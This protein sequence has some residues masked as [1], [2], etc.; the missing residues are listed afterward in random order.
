MN[1][2]ICFLV[3]TFNVLSNFVN[4]FEFDGSYDSKIDPIRKEIFHTLMLEER[5][6]KNLTEEELEREK[7]KDIEAN[8]W[9]KQL[10]ASAKQRDKQK[11]LTLSE[12]IPLELYHCLERKYQ[13]LELSEKN[14]RLFDRFYKKYSSKK[15]FSF[16]KHSPKGF[17]SIEKKL[18]D[19][20]SLP[21]VG[22]EAL[23]PEKSF[24]ELAIDLMERIFTQERLQSKIYRNDLSKQLTSYPLED[25][26]DYLG[27]E[28]SPSDLE[29]FFSPEGQLLYY[30]IYESLHLYLVSE[31]QL[32]HDINLVKQHFQKSLADPDIRIEKIKED[33]LNKHPSLL[34]L[35][36]CDPR[37]LEELTG[38]GF[39]LTVGEQNVADG[40]VVLLEKD[41]WEKEYSLVPIHEYRRSKEGKMNLIIARQKRSHIPFLLA[42]CHG[43]S[44]DPS[45]GR[46]QISII[47]KK[48][49]TLQKKE[50]NLQLLIG[51]DA[52][53]KSQE[54]V[55]S[56]Y[57]HLESLG[58]VCTKVG[59]TT[60]KRRM[61][62]TEQEKAAVYIEDQEEYLIT[63]GENRDRIAMLSKPFLRFDSKE[64]GLL[65]NPSNLSDHYPVGAYIIPAADETPSKEG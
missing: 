7:P 22:S 48:Y 31:K 14:W 13:E 16:W 34:F 26:K 29:P 51:I 52:N 19:L 53:T 6:V 59:A 60:I 32:I 46:E 49:E 15:I 8:I 17:L 25:L 23:L 9:K 57:N 41:H 20:S 10:I 11:G 58:L 21:I 54:E 56:F 37:L 47:M 40:T 4:P 24:E 65:P 62:T 50:P 43:A 30:W 45:D 61:V 12:L 28:S 63:L 42:S 64:E 27:N 35:Q 36:E 39:F 1:Q 44:L 33:L 55:D 38:D 3:I 18:S 2:I 5:L